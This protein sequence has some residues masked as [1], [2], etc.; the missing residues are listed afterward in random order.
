MAFLYI[1]NTRGNRNAGTERERS[2]G[3]V[4]KT[5]QGDAGKTDQETFMAIRCAVLATLVSRRLRAFTSI[6]D[7]T[8]LLPFKKP[9]YTAVTANW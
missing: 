7:K 8:S 4:G 1:Y 2:R 9:L 5:D 3:D 6:T